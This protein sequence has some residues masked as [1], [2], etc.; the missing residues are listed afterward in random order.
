MDSVRGKKQIDVSAAVILRDDEVLLTSRDDREHG[1][2]YWEFPGG[3]R[4]PGETFAQCLRR[5]L[6]EELGLEV[7]MFE[8]M[9]CLRYEYPDKLVHLHFIRCLPVEATAA[10]RPREGQ[11]CRWAP[12]VRL[13]ESGLLPADAAFAEFLGRTVKNFSEKDNK[14]AAVGV[15]SL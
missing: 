8:P 6:R 13:A 1:R 7:R 3:K 5:E 4:E 15:D 2:R 10:I 14:S 9:Y 12:I 11:D